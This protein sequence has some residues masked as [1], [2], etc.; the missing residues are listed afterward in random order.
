LS[1]AL[2]AKDL[3]GKLVVVAGT[4]D[5]LGRKE[6]KQRL[7]A[8]GART[9]SIVSA[10]VDLVF[11]GAR[12]GPREGAAEAYGIT[13]HDELTL[14]RVLGLVRNGEAAIAP[15]DRILWHAVMRDGGDEAFMVAADRLMKLGDPRGDLIQTQMMLADPTTRADR[16]ALL[17]QRE[18]ELL[19]EHGE[20]W[21]G[22]LLPYVLEFS[23]TVRPIMAR[24]FLAELETSSL[25]LELADAVAFS[26]DA[27]YL[28]RLSV[29]FARSLKP[30]SRGQY[31]NLRTLHLG[32]HRQGRWIVA[33][34]GLAKLLSGCPRLAEVEL[35][36]RDRVEDDLLT[37]EHGELR[38]L[39]LHQMDRYPLANLAH[40]ASLSG[41]VELH[42]VPSDRPRPAR[43][44][45]SLDNVRALSGANTTLT[46]LTHLTLRNGDFGDAGLT[47]LLEAPFFAQLTHLDLADGRISDVGAERLAAHPNARGLERL[48]LRDN[49]VTELGQRRIEAALPNLRLS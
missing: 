9:T 16:R 41:L 49:P 47:Y 32:D 19:T 11:L 46:G 48:V 40:N 36:I 21:L 20:A 23:P 24:G 22:G 15:D 35:C 42:C 29:S 7:K 25:S 44:V 17:Q 45:L 10:K 14:K 1:D 12:P 38:G 6:A 18:R 3:D 34:E 4:F 30:L 37:S 8:L 5:G 39:S 2:T 13:T 31:P 28:R 33:S 26:P 27:T 43:R